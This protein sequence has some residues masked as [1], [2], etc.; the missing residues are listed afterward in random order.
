MP[1][2]TRNHRKCVTDTLS[3]YEEVG[4]AA[5]LESSRWKTTRGNFKKRKGKKKEQTTG[6]LESTV[7]LT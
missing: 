2:K 7:L 6:W 5:I 1:V 4:G 3:S